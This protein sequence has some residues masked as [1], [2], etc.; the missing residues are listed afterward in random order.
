MGFVEVPDRG[1]PRVQR[2]AVQRRP[3]PVARGVGQVGDHHM[4]VQVRVPGPGGAVPE[5]RG[6][7]PIGVDHA[8]AALAA[9]HP[10]R[11]P[12]QHPQRPGH[13]RVGGVADLVGHLRRTEREQQ[14]HRLGRTERHIEPGHHQVPTATPSAGTYRWDPH[15]PAHGVGPRR[16]PHRTAPA[17]R[18]P[19]PP[20]PRAPPWHPCS[21]PPARERPCPGSTAAGPA[22][23]SPSSTPPHRLH[24]RP[25][26]AMAQHGRCKCVAVLGRVRGGRRECGHDG[27]VS[28]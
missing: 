23:A 27:W 21:T 20:T 25:A 19:S 5:R 24:R 22:P 4:G 16:R 17:G 14:R 3:P 13:G 8:V 15:V 9:A 11:H 2:P 10:A 12:L 28:P 1:Q 7:E 26:D 6:H 18:T